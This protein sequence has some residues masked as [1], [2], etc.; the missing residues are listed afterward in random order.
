[1]FP[2]GTVPFVPSWYAHGY[3]NDDDATLRHHS[4]V[5]SRFLPN[6]SCPDLPNAHANGDAQFS[7]IVPCMPKLPSL[8]YDL[9]LF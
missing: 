7:T 9:P 4:P 5:Y 8:F 6:I 3:D 2:L 1:M